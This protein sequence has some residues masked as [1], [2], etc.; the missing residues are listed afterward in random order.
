MSSLLL[1]YSCA[2]IV[3]HNW[4]SLSEYRIIYL[5]IVAGVQLGQMGFECAS[6]S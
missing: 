5:H 6:I 3:I 2:I 4:T 1:H